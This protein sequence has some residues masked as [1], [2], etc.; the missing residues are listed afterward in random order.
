MATPSYIPIDVVDLLPILD[1]KLID[2]LK[3]LTPADWY[4]QTIA[5][6]WKVKD[7]TAHLLDGNIRGLSMLR[8]NYYGEQADVKTQ[9][10]LI[11]FLNRL[12]ADWVTAMKRVSPDM[13]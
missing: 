10:D 5:K 12:N 4:K 6:R 9:Q 1:K 7:L 13:L 2:L 8:D 11:D 3:D